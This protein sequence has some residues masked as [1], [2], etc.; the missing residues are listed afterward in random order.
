MGL[1]I[2]YSMFDFSIK[3]FYLE[4]RH[5]KI[6][7]LGVP[8]HRNFPNGLTIDLPYVYLLLVLSVEYGPK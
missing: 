7:S 6:L 2:T 5:I 4:D 8:L 1:A 3:G